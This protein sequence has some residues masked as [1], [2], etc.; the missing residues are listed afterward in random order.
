MRYKPLRG[1]AVRYKRIIGPHSSPYRQAYFGNTGSC[2]NNSSHGI[3]SGK[4][5]EHDIKRV[6][7]AAVDGMIIENEG[8]RRAYRKASC[9]KKKDVG[10]VKTG[11]GQ[12][13][14]SCA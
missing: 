2:K 11:E 6:Y 9:G 1:F 8:N 10:H 12:N 14:F 3:L 13:T 5:K 4:L 7:V